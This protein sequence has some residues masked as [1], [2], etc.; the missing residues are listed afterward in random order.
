[1]FQEERGAADSY[2]LTAVQADAILKMTLGQLVNLEQERLGDEHRKLLE[3]I[4]EYLRILSDEQNILDIIKEDLREIKRKHGDDR[5]TEITG[6][7]VGS[8]D[9]EDLITEEAMVVS[10]SHRGY[11]KRTPTSVY[12]RSGAGA[13]GSA[14]LRRRKKTRSSTCSWP[15]PTPTCCSLP[16]RARSSGKRS[17]ACRS[18]DAKAKAGRSSIC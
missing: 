3:E 2:A 16:T 15:A 6:E 18:W 13:K 10:I 12:R 9:L 4:A 1:M 11:I 5:R 17:S 8:L 14:A 7:E